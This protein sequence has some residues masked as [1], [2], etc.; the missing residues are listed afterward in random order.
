M[1]IAHHLLAQIIIGNFTTPC[2]GP[3]QENALV[4]GEPVEH[5]RWFSF[6]RSAIGVKRECETSQ[7]RDIFTHGQLA[8]YFH[9]RQRFILRLLF[10]QDGGTRFESGSVF[11]RPPIAQRP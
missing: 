9:A 6:K 8:I 5:W 7:V 10:A 3:T 11:L 4:A 2:L 1:R